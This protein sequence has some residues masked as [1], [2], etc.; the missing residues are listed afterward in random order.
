MDGLSWISL[1]LVASGTLTGLLGSTYGPVIAS[2]SGYVNLLTTIMAWSAVCGDAAANILFTFMATAFAFLSILLA[3][4]GIVGVI[5]SF[6]ISVIMQ[7]L[8]T[9]LSSDII[10]DCDS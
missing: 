8:A 9:R 6:G 4:T 10:G 1:S 2:I 5:V 7:A 3:T